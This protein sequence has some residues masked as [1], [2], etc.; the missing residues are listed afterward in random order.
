MMIQVIQVISLIIL[1]ICLILKNNVLL[2]SRS[3]MNEIIETIDVNIH[4]P[5]ALLMEKKAKRYGYRL[6]QLAT[7]K[8]REANRICGTMA[9]RF[10]NRINDLVHVIKLL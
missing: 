9:Y 4:A 2:Y 3:E 5:D 10:N 7:E 8:G 1:N 6:A